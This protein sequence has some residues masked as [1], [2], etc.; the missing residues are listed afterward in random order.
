MSNHWT[1]S[2]IP[3]LTGNVI[4]VTGANSGI[5]Y[6]AALELAR[7]GGRTILACRSMDKAQT[8]LSQIQAQVPNA[9]VEI[10]QLDLA[11]QASIRA[12]AAAFNAR[13]DRLDRLINNAG[14]M[15]VPYGTTDDGFERQFGTN[16]LG[17][18]ALTGLLIDRIL[19][20][21]GARV[22]NISSG[23]HRT[24]SMDFDNLMYE[25][26]KGYTPMQAYGRSKLANL[27]FTYELQR[28]FE[29]IGADAR[30]T[31][32]HPGGSNT[33]LANHMEDR[34]LF[35]LAR[36]LL[37]II[38]QSAAMGALP[39]LRAAADP[40][41]VGGAYFGPGGFSEMRGYPVIVESSAAAHDA[42]AARK[43]WSVSEELTGVTMPQLD[44]KAA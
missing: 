24:G 23:A 32:A 17:H 30:A 35:R 29:A 14:I 22:V 33:N 21:P 10:M 7:K 27:L 8:A 2:A 43:L 25:G 31:A 18:F 26:G 41:A 1:T 13:Y 4:I 11:S 36:P 42:A 3:D 20:T 16:H 15:M 37:A 5:G 12:F 28:R 39:T 40:Q 6:E 9:S 34:L 38:M 44:G 19:T